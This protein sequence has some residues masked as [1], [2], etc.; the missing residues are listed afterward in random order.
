MITGVGDGL[1]FSSL[2]LDDPVRPSVSLFG[3]ILE[4][5]VGGINGGGFSF[6][7]DILPSEMS[8]LIILK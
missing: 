1:V 6:N 2:S 7:P 3:D 8:F 5:G 4:G